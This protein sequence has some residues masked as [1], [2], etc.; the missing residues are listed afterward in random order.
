MCLSRFDI[1]YR[2]GLAIHHLQHPGRHATGSTFGILVDR[3]IRKSPATTE[4]PRYASL[5]I[6][7]VRLRPSQPLEQQRWSRTVVTFEERI[8]LIMK[9]GKWSYYQR[10][11]GPGGSMWWGMFS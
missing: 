9:N 10:I 4:I 8:R 3:F 6:L 2:R 5:R 11:K 1:A 7:I